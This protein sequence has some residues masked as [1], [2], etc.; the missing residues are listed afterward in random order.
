[1]CFFF[2]LS[3]SSVHVVLSHRESNKHTGADV[4]ITCNLDIKEIYWYKIKPPDAPVF[5]LSTCDS[6]SQPMGL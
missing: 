6:Q 1:M 4:N 5:M 3:H 2:S